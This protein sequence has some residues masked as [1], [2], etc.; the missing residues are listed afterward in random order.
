[1]TYW[2]ND[3]SLLWNFQ[4]FRSQ[5]YEIKGNY[6][7]K[8]PESRVEIMRTKSKL[9]HKKSEL[10]HKSWNIMSKLRQ[11][12]P[13]GEK[14]M[15]LCFLFYFIITPLQ[16]IHSTKLWFIQIFYVNE[17]NENGSLTKNICFSLFK[18]LFTS[19]TPLE[20]IWLYMVYL[21]M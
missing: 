8:S 12:S 20:R 7:T 16:L 14:I 3:Y 6:E 21:A 15:K 11:I 9:W 10:S 4:N 5:K 1:M 18:K 13:N 2:H 19:K 17:V